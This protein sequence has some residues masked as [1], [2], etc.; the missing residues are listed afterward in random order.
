MTK[1]K[2]AG[3]KKRRNGE[4]KRLKNKND[5]SIRSKHKAGSIGRRPEPGRVKGAQMTGVLAVPR[6]AAG[7][8]HKRP[9]SFASLSRICGECTQS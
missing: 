4:R 3:D 5:R 9:G 7:K 8:R 6:D 2:S 1:A